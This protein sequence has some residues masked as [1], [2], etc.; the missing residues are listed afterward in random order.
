MPDR[1]LEFWDD[2]GEA[3]REIVRSWPKDVQ[4]AIGTDLRRVQRRE[5]PRNWKPL[6]D[7]PV[8]AA[9]VRHKSGARIVYSVAFAD[10]SDKVFV[11]DAFMKDSAEGS[12]MRAADRRR[13]EKRLKAYK[14]RYEKQ[15]ARKLH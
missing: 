15:R 9:E 3:F 11:V 8:A 10:V 4:V 14:A 12:E 2:D 6:K 7:F 1:D 5:E 13:I